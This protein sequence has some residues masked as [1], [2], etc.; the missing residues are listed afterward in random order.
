MSLKTF[1]LIFVSAAT[2]LAFGCAVWA[3]KNYQAPEGRL[4]DLLF[5]IGSALA[6]A[7]LIA[8]ERYFLK[9]TK[10]VGYL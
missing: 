5:G 8:Y 6:G 1:H 4:G 9:K 2:L 3:L 7:A 10:D